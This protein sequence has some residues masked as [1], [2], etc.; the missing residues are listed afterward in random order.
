MSNINPKWGSWATPPAPI[1][2]EQIIER[3]ETDVL[4]I[5]AGVAGMTCA[6]RA[7]ETG[8]NVTVLEKTGSFSARGA[9]IGVVNSSLLRK[10]GHVNDPETVAREWIKRCGNRCDERLV[11]L[12]IN[13]SERAMDW[14]LEL[15]TRPEYDTH[16]I[17]Q[18]A[19][20]KGETYYEILGP[21]MF[22]GGPMSRQGK[23][24]GMNDVLFPMHEEMMKLGVTFMYNSPAEQ[25][26]KEN[27][28][29][30]GAIAKTNDGYISVKARHGVVLST[31]CI[32][33]NDEMCDD[34]APLANK[35]PVKLYTPVGANTGDGHRMGLWAGG[36]FDDGHFPTIMHPQAHRHASFCF[37]FVDNNG[38]RFMNEDSYLQG[39]S[40][41]ILREGM[42]YAW[43]I[44]DSAWREKVPQ[45]LPYGGGL[46]WGND[47][48]LGQSEFNEK[49]E[50]DR[51]KLGLESGTTFEAD[52]PGELAEKMSIPVDV[53][54]E[55]FRRYNEMAA[56]G[57]DLEFGKRKELLIPIDKP[58]YIA[59]RFGPALLAV[60]GG[61]RV[62]AQMRVLAEDREPIPGLY[63]IGN[64]AGGRYGV[65]YPMLIPGNN[66]GTALTFGFVLGE[67][68]GAATKK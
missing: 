4:V 42:Q 67:A 34:L 15:V 50:S 2:D 68:L 47:C 51:M 26:I 46:Y 8:A 30:T 23:F 22:F 58:P 65:D 28:R 55:T 52:T 31:G 14:L 54:E 62:D 9:N 60:A 6:Y 17:L 7:A 5:G 27:G 44:F 13:N 63:A 49:L 43:S 11:W 36:S 57:K 25:L 48:E 16:P 59:R 45:S 41:A 37:L 1:P 35:C 53:F 39:K 64:T 3:Y 18:G 24:G 32:G 10:A 29:I 12:Y 56:N 20:Y 38:R 66:H 33:G 21:H 40:V 61:L 19:L